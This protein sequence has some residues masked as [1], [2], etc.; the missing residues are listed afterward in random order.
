MILPTK[1]ITGLMIC[2]ILLFA[3]QAY[4]AGKKL[5]L[6]QIHNLKNSYQEK[7]DTAEQDES[8]SKDY[9][10]TMALSDR[11]ENCQGYGMDTFILLAY[12]IAIVRDAGQPETKSESMQYMA[13][14]LALEYPFDAEEINSSAANRVSK[15]AIETA[16]DHPGSDD[17]HL[18]NIASIFWE[19]CL[20]LPISIFENELKDN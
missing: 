9:I 16:V 13:G 11:F 3:S 14:Q 18:E 15:L 4:A 8:N 7:L 12:H 5:T 2:T 6:T 20:N 19:K 1:Q 17:A 10:H